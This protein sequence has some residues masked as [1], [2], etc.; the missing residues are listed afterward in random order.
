MMIYLGLGKAN[1]QS[2]YKNI[3]IDRVKE[4]HN[5]TTML[6]VSMAHCNTAKLYTFH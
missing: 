6:H 3:A 1:C 5:C 4:G 2:Y